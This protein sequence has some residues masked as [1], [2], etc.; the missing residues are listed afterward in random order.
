MRLI[1]NLTKIVLIVEYDGKGYSGFQ[2]QTNLPTIQGELENGILKLTGERVR[3]LGASRT[4]RGVHA[5]EQVVSFRIR[6]SLPLLAFVNGM[7][8]Y[9]PINIAVKAAYKV[10]NSFN[11]RR[12]A[13]SREYKYYILNSQTRS[14]IRKDYTYMVRGKLDITSMNGACQEL[15]GEHDFASFVTHMEDRI[16]IT[17]RNVYNANIE[18]DGELVIFDIKANSFLPHQVRNIVGTLIKIGLGK[19]NIAEFC[20]IM[21]AKIPGLAGPTVPACGLCLT[22]I[23]YP[24]PLGEVE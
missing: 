3:I 14:P 17:V 19:I 18:K 15:I 21:E 10:N 12:D 24:S 23:Y 11:P 22:K 20:D 2:F 16:K 9:L 7:N 1:N 4:D 8:Y 5:R 6:S 13:V